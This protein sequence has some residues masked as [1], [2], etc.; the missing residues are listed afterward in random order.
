MAK[1]KH[2]LELGQRFNGLTYLS[3]VHTLSGNRRCLWQCTCGNIKEITLSR[4]LI[5]N[6]KSCGCAQHSKLPAG[7]AGFNLI[8]YKYQMNAKRRKYEFNL[9]IAE[10][11]KLIS[12]NCD[13]CGEE[14]SNISRGGN[15][16]TKTRL[17]PMD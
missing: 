16:S 13:Y 5:G 3:D 1:N 10:F 15:L 4:V 7:E 14:P 6:C 8:Y 17:L 11:R 2:T 12:S 9:D